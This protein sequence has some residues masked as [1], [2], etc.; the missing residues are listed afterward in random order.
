MSQKPVLVLKAD[1]LTAVPGGGTQLVVGGKGRSL[2]DLFNTAFRG[3][4]DPKGPKMGQRLGA[5]ADLAGR[6]A[7]AAATLQSTA[8]QMQGGN[9]FA[10]LGA[11]AQYQANKPFTYRGEVYNPP[12]P[13]SPA[14]PIQN[15]TSTATPPSMTPAPPIQQPTPQQTQQTQQTPAPPIPATPAPVPPVQQSATAPQ[16]GNVQQDMANAMTPPPGQSQLPTTPPTPLNPQ[17]MGRAA[18][19]QFG[20]N[21]P[22]PMPQAAQPT[23]PVYVQQPLPAFTATPPGLEQAFAALGTPQQAAPRQPAQSSTHNP[24]LGRALNTLAPSNSWGG[25]VNELPRNWGGPSMIPTDNDWSP[26][27]VKPKPELGDD[28]LWRAFAP[29]CFPTEDGMLRKA[30]PHE[31]GLY[32]ALRY[33]GWL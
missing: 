33:L 7:A 29:F 12:Q 24:S 28:V 2:R 13:L 9:M 10:P 18:Q 19:P 1:S 30:T 8:E 20:A 25:F 11:A 22:T 3:R 21:Q 26:N 23:G 15:P 16:S 17:Q 31:V 4:K 32:A 27:Y 5:M 6:G 14:P